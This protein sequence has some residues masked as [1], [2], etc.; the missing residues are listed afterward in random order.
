[1]NYIQY[2]ELVNCAST[3]QEK[4]TESIPE[5]S[6]EDAEVLLKWK[7][8]IKRFERMVLIYW[9]KKSKKE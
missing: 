8:F 9:L 5:C 7:R 3:I 4:L 1:M 6:I 2:S